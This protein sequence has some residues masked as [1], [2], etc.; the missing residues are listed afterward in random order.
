MFSGPQLV[1]LHCLYS[2]VAADTLT[3]QG[4][5]AKWGLT[6]S[7]SLAFPAATAASTDAQAHLVAD[8]SLSKGRIQNGGDDLSFIPDPFPNSPAPGITSDTTGPALQVVYPAGSFNNNTGGAQFFSLWNTTES[9]GFQTV[10][11]SYE[12][13][14]D[15]DFDWVKGG[16]LP[17][18]RSAGSDTGCSGGKEANGIDCFTV[19]LM[20]RPDGAGEAYAYIPT[21][22]KLCA[23]KSIVCNSDFGTS[24]SRG[25]F[26][27]ASGRWNRITLL[28]SMNDP[29]TRANGN[30]EIY[31][32][33]VQAFAQQDLQIRAVSN[34]SI[35]GMFFSTFFG[36]SDDSWATP[37]TTHTYF[38][39]LALYGGYT[40][41][42][43]TGNSNAATL[44]SPDMR[45][46]TLTFAVLALAWV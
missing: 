9:V 37:K 19:R 4:L 42:N 44:R 7:T 40:P 11:L 28:V 2:L 32:N 30:V 22:K 21:S 35:G 34:M 38:R 27:F 15:S 33:D 29:P 18:L 41:S 13:A 23:E 12:V 26:T 17:G 45:I 39:N 25:S 5:A 1:L 16:K 8:W 36:G 46:L 10:A 31:F 14:F 24:I 3:P 43:L 20:W 6:T